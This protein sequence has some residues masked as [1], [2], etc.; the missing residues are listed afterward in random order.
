VLR[1]DEIERADEVGRRVDQRAVEVE[2][3]G[4]HVLSPSGRAPR[5]QAFAPVTHR[6]GRCWYYDRGP[7][8]ATHRP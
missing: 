6:D 4:E 1:E 2:D 3:D 7:G 5:A 8:T